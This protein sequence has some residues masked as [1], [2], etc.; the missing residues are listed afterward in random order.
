MMMIT[1]AYSALLPFAFPV[2]GTI[3]PSLAAG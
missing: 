1:L 3:M 2:A